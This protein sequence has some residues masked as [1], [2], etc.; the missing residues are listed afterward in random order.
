[1]F[2][3]QVQKVPIQNFCMNLDLSRLAKRLVSE[4]GLKDLSL[5]HLA[6]EEYKKFFFLLG[7]FDEEE[8]MY[9][10]SAIVDL[11]WQRHLLDTL[12]YHED[13]VAFDIANGYLH[14]Y[15]SERVPAEDISN[16]NNNELKIDLVLAYSTTLDKYRLLFGEPPEQIWPKMVSNT[17]FA[18]PYHHDNVINPAESVALDL[19]RPAITESLIEELMWIG[20]IV[21]DSLPKKQLQCIDGQ[22]ISMIAFPC[23]MDKRESVRVTVLEYIRFLFLLMRSYSCVEEKPLRATTME[24][25]VTPSKLVDELW[26]AHILQSTSYYAFW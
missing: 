14:R 22:P 20:D 25:E 6:I 9:L 17:A 5:A 10:P 15:D 8:V 12:N 11:V 21:Y 4:D 7:E 24:G 26:H 1:M 19:Y 13:C 3:L 23:G 16:P 18:I 2:I